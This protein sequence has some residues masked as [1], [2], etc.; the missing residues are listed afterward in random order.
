MDALK[1]DGR[2]AGSSALLAAAG[3]LPDPLK[4]RAARM[5]SSPRLYNLIVSNV[6]GPRTPLYACGSRVRS[7]HPVV[8]IP[9][10][11]AL[12]IGVLTCRA[13]AAHFLLLRGPAGASACRGF[14]DRD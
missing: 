7:I 2:I 14:G 9:D 6:P 1:R 10:R 12:S 3:V 4:D 11:H 5:A 13:Q 8:P